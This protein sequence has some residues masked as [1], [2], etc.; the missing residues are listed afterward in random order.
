MLYYNEILDNNNC[1]TTCFIKRVIIEFTQNS[2]HDHF[3]SYKYK[4]CV[5]TN[6]LY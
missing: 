3:N 6:F 4:K 5:N 2:W 1:S